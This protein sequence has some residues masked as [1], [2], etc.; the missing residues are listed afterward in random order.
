[1]SQHT[2]VF[3]PKFP[4]TQKRDQLKGRRPNKT[5]RFGGMIDPLKGFR[6]I[7]DTFS[8]VHP[9]DEQDIELSLRRN[10]GGLEPAEVDTIVL[11]AQFF[12]REALAQK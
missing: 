3:G 10:P 6:Q 12:W 2:G 4:L 9:A 7:L 8:Q 5:Q 11:Q 1:M